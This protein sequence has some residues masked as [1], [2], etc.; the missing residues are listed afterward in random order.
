MQAKWMMVSL[1]GLGLA[2][3]CS[4]MKDKEAGE[5]KLT[6]DQV[7]AAV[8]TTL[9]KESGGANF[10]SVDKETDDGKNVY[11]ADAMIDGK[12]Y[13]IKVADDGTLISKKL[14]KEEGE[15]KGAKDKD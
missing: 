3:G 2:A 14:D 9:G 15:K 10:T 8:K 6:L 1:I 4:Q 5:V 11:E 13:E 12:N 7:P